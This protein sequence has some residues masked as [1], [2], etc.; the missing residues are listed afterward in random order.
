MKSV[1]VCPMCKNLAY[2]NSYFGAYICENCNWEDDS[3]AKERD[4]YVFVSSSQTL[5]KVRSAAGTVT[6]AKKYALKAKK[7]S[8]RQK[9]KVAIG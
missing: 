1:K 8:D 3:Y 7:D 5:V 6:V 4:A 9:R 2:F